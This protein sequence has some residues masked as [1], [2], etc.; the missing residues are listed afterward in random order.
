MGKYCS[1]KASSLDEDGTA[2]I[3]ATLPSEAKCIARGRG[4]LASGF[5]KDGSRLKHSFKTADMAA[6]EAAMA[7][8]MR[9]YHLDEKQYCTHNMHLS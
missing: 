8:S 4:R 2:A 9:L 6:Y 5:V 3:G 7:Y 1:T